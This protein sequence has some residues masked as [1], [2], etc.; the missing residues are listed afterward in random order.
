[1]RLK[2]QGPPSRV[3]APDSSTIMFV[4]P[5]HSCPVTVGIVCRVTAALFCACLF[6]I[7]YCTRNNILL[8]LLLLYLSRH[9]SKAVI[10]GGNLCSKTE[11]K[12][13]YYV[14]MRIGRRYDI[15][16]A[17]SGVMG[18]KCAQS[19]GDCLRGA[20]GTIQ[21]MSVPEN[22]MPRVVPWDCS[23]KPREFEHVVRLVHV[24]YTLN[25]HR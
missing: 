23:E 10:Y 21:H 25:F 16:S 17:K 24:V 5:Y 18:A 9:F 20:A 13:R 19:V 6:S 7:Y 14:F 22:I 15:H 1:M 12:R 11:R 3:A 2:A 8:H 4:V